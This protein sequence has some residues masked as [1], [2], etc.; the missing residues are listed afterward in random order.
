MC[1]IRQ[2]GNE[3]PEACFCAQARWISNNEV[4]RREVSE[5]EFEWLG[6]YDNVINSGGIK[7]HP[8]KIEHKLSKLIQNRFFTIGI[9]DER[10]GEKL[11]LVIENNT[12][13]TD[14]EEVLKRINESIEITKYEV[15]KEIYF[16]KNFIET[17]TKKIQRLKTLDLVFNASK[18]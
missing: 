1:Q 9:K 3:F 4:R 14:S 11:V 18:K 15:P 7:L 6:R 10:L 2:K 13:K 5:N 16:V 12:T 8:E 17:E